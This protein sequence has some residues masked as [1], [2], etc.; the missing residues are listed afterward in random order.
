MK[1]SIQN[2]TFILFKHS[3]TCSR[4]AMVYDRILKWQKEKEYD[5]LYILRIQEDR[6]LSS[7]VAQQTKIKHESPQLLIYKSGSVITHENRLHINVSFLD[8]I[9]TKIVL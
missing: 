4:S 9:W 7:Y 1:K 5:E 6:D 8:A 3:I 2:K